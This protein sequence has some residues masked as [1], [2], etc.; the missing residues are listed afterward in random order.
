MTVTVERPGCSW[1]DVAFLPW[2]RAGHRGCPL[3]AVGGSCCA[4]CQLLT[5]WT[6]LCHTLH[7]SCLKQK[8]KLICRHV[9]L[10][11]VP[12][13]LKNINGSSRQEYLP[14]IPKL[15]EFKKD[16]NKFHLT[17]VGVGGLGL[18]LRFL[19]ELVATAVFC[20]RRVSRC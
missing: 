2:R 11:P 8:E 14:H 13:F 1:L 5:A 15:K 19:T 18:G 20:V 3:T 9:G 16:L 4:N 6:R 7:G 12:Y 10:S 17:K